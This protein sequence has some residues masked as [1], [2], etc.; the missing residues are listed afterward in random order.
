MAGV[1]IDESSGSS[2]MPNNWVRGPQERQAVKRNLLMSYALLY[3]GNFFLL[4]CFAL[5][6]WATGMNVSMSLVDA[7]IMKS[8]GPDKLK[9][10]NSLKTFGQSYK[11]LIMGYP[12]FI[13]NFIDTTALDLKEYDL[14][15]IVGGEGLSEGLRDYFLNFF[16]TVRSSYGASDLEINIGIETEFS[17]NLR[18]MCSQ[19]PKLSK[20]IFGRQDVPMIFQYNP[21]D[22]IVEQSPQGELVFTLTRAANVAP[23][24]RYNI[25]DS[26]GG[27]SFRILSQKLKEAGI[28]IKNICQAYLHFPVLYVYGRNDLSVPFYGAKVF[29]TDID[30]VINGDEKLQK[31]YNSFRMKVTE[32]EKLNKTLLIA[33]ERSQNVKISFP[34]EELKGVFFKG[35]Q[36]VNQDFRE[37]SKIFTK[38]NLSIEQYD[39]GQGPFVTRDIRVKNNYFL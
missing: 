25:K 12:P 31:A 1:V 33:L 6:P 38:D 24:I 36:D 9:L 5:G 10:E 7:A 32:D 21:A 4:N 14:H 22:Y 35:L 39:Y 26:G 2:G 30:G 28:E 16:K 3:D 27:M 17:I 18:K 15:L 11:Y 13:K 37:V 29:P 8:I 20:A 19:N 34:G 23:K